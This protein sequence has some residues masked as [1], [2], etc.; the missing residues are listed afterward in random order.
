MFAANAGEEDVCAGVHVQQ[1]A[2]AADEGP[3]YRSLHSTQD[4]CCA[5]EKKKFVQEFMFS[6]MLWQPMKT[7]RVAPG[8]TARAGANA[9]FQTR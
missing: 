5:Q 7:F 6:E 8:K 9:F 2:V 1:D 3:A 4:L